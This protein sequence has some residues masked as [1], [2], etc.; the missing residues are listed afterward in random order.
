MAGFLRVAGLVALLAGGCAVLPV[1]QVPSPAGVREAA[2][3]SV[4]HGGLQVTAMPAAPV[5]VHQAC[6]ADLRR[7]LDHLM[8]E[9]SLQ[10]PVMAAGTETL[11]IAAGETIVAYVVACHGQATKPDDEPEV[12]TGDPVGFA[13]DFWYTPAGTPLPMTGGFQVA[14]R[15]HRQELAAVS[16]VGRRDRPGGDM[17]FRTVSKPPAIATALDGLFDRQLRPVQEHFYPLRFMPYDYGTTCTEWRSGG[18]VLGYVDSGLTGTKGNQGRYIGVQ[19]WN[20]LD[21]DGTPVYAF[22]RALEPLAG[23]PY[24]PVTL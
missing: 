6:V 24:H 5:A 9:E 20:L 2:G 21:A 18:T 17:T 7:Y 8:R 13:V 23:T 1:S 12:R 14:V 4:R 3:P 19:A 10:G 22:G 16:P 15:A 11:A